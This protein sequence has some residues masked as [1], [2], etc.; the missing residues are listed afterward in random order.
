MIYSTFKAKPR[1]PYVR[2]ESVTNWPSA[3]TTPARAAIKPIASALVAQ[4]KGE[5]AKPGKRAPTAAERAWMDW[6]VSIGCIACRL[7][8]M[9]PR[10]TAVHHILRGGVRMGHLHTLGLCDPGHHQGG[11]PLGLISRHPW[12]Q[13]FEQR[14]GTEAELLEILR[15]EYSA[16]DTR[17][18]S[19][20]K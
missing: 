8:S 19:A 14:Y 2:P 16:L 15:K 12:K 13:Q 17:A 4:P 20:I 10:P 11:E 18:K 5:A 1:A 6:I 3:L 9:P 7:D